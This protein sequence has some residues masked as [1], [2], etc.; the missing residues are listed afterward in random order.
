MFN[1]QDLGVGVGRALKCVHICV[2][3][4]SENAQPYSSIYGII[5]R[6]MSLFWRKVACV[7]FA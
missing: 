6:R 3:L 2:Y 4:K 1:L 5:Y 7:Y